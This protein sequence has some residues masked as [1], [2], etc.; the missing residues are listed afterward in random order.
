MRYLLPALVFMLSQLAM[1]QNVLTKFDEQ[2]ANENFSGSSALFS[3]KYNVKELFQI[4]NGK[5]KLQR[6]SET[7]Y[8]VSYARVDEELKSHSFSANIQLSKSKN[9]DASGGI[10]I[11]AQHDGS[12][13]IILE[14]N[15]K[16]RFRLKK[17]YN[18][19]IQWLSGSQNEGWVKS[20]MLS[21]NGPNLLEI[22]TA[23]GYYDI[24]INGVY[25]YSSFDLQFNTGRCGLYVNAS[26]EI[27]VSE[28]L[29]KREMRKIEV[30]DPANTKPD[31]SNSPSF[32]EIILI[33]NAKIDKQQKEIERLE[34]ELNKCKSMLNYDTALLTQSSQLRSENA[35]MSQLLDSISKE[36]NA[37]KKRLEYLE[38]F[39]EDIEAA[40]NGDLVINLSNV[41]AQL[42]TENKA[43][44]SKNSELSSQN[45]EL[46]KENEIL[47]REL[48]RL[49]KLL[50]AQ[51]K[52]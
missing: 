47:H 37:A 22:R 2:V 28:V 16:K 23:K 49:R 33:F 25:E 35:R 24:Y 39:K 7:D 13:A 44:E 52:Q 3:Q 18:Q 1:G 42:K 12:G 51:D 6:L 8:S 27:L 4:E 15:S 29:I 11:H 17:V 46:K 34:S 45:A 48:E 32:Q 30:K 31:S 10:V 38:S 19:Q 40:S 50:E 21:K 41:L 43:L 26:S 9:K 36:L 5:Y 20:K 14:I